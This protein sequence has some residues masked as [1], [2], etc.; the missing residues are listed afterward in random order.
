MVDAS[1][2]DMWDAEGRR[3]IDF[4]MGSAAQM[5]ALTLITSFVPGP[6]TASVGVIIGSLFVVRFL[7]GA[8]HAPIF[9]VMNAS[10][11]RSSSPSMRSK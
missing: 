9:P 4:K 3:Y 11:V 5:I 8:V 10:I 1:I 6:G 7:V 2:D